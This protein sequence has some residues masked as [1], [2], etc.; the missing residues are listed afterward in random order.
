MDPEMLKG[1][2]QAYAEHPEWETSLEYTIGVLLDREKDIVARI[3]ENIRAFASATASSRD[4]DTRSQ[5]LTAAM[6]CVG[7]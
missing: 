5:R 4:D 7:E 2:K 6:L 1:Y 3:V